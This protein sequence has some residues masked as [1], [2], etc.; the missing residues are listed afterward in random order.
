MSCAVIAAIGEIMTSTTEQPG[1][2]PSVNAE[3]EPAKKPNVGK[4][5]GHVASTSVTPG[6]KAGPAKAQRDRT[7]AKVA[8][9]EART[10][11]KTA[12]ILELLRRP[13]GATAK[14][15]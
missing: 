9:Q 13:G 12:K 7:K 15:L 11:S 14:E 1:S 8:Q 10:G 4:R 6:K 3:Q 5:A 2:A